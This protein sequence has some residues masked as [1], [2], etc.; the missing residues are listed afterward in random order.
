M[1]IIMH[2]DEMNKIEVRDVEK[3]PVFDVFYEVFFSMGNPSIFIFGPNRIKIG[4]VSY[5]K[6]EIKYILFVELFSL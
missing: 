1:H 5:A 6:S 3:Y 4:H 2:S